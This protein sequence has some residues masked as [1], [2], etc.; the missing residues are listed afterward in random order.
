M[1]KTHTHT[2]ETQP[3]V[4]WLLKRVCPSKSMAWT[5]VKLYETVSEFKTFTQWRQM[6]RVT[7]PH[8]NSGPPAVSLPV[9]CSIQ[10]SDLFLFGNGRRN[11]QKKLANATDSAHVKMERNKIA[12]RN[13]RIAAYTVPLHCSRAAFFVVVFP[14]FSA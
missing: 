10:I 6:L 13:K 12:L 14:F 11:Q 2:H 4:K 5:T 7:Q 3:F 9:P 8:P 1:I